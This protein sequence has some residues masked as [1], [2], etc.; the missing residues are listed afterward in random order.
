MDISE[1]YKIIYKQNL[2]ISTD[3]RS[4]ED[5]SVFVALK[6][7]NFDG[8]AFA[9]KAL[10]KGA[11]LVFVDDKKYSDLENVIYVPDTLKMIQELAVYHRDKFQIPFIAITGSN[12]KT[13]TK[14]LVN[15]VLLEKYKTHC[16]KGNLNNH[17]GVPLTILSIQTDTEMAIIEMG[18]NHK[19]E[20]DFLCKISKP[21]YGYIT[22][23]GRAHLEGFGNLEGVIE[24][25]S[26]LYNFL[27]N[28]SAKVFVN[29]ADETQNTILSKKGIIDIIPFG[30]DSN[31]DINLENIDPFVSVN[32]LGKIIKSNLIGSYNFYNISAAIAIGE[33]FGLSFEQ[34]KDG[35]QKYFPTNNRSQ[36]LKKEDLEIILDA[37]NANPSSME[38]ALSSLSNQS[39]VVLI[40]GDMAELGSFSEEEHQKLVFLIEQRNFHKTY[41]LGDQ[42]FKTNITKPNIYKYRDIENLKSDLKNDYFSN[43]KI[44]IKGSRSMKLEELIH[45]F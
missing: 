1:I 45:I 30:P 24:G 12:G 22:N 38:I 27:K 9:K 10:S 8:N 16:T 43:K 2:R 13:T 17:I 39:D 33:H 40:L 25:K 28:N 6:G 3:T 21:N 41:L 14:E 15:S 34:I 18:A 44:F 20:I 5:N 36:V 37:Y 11:K 23:F 4:I 35:I 29:T 32:Y 26:E 7:E 19:G 31:T 42:F